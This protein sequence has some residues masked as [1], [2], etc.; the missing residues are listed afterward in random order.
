[1]FRLAFAL[2]M[3]FE[4]GGLQRSFLRIALRCAELGHD[5]HVYTGKWVGEK[6]DHLTVRVLNTRALTNVG[7]N[8]RLAS[9]LQ[10][11]ARDYDC[12]VGFTKIPGLDVYYAGDTCYAARVAENRHRLYKL[13]PR[14]RGYIRQEAGV[15]G[16]R[17]DTEILLIA[18]GE[19]EKFMHHY[20]TDLERFHLLPP[21]VD[22][23]RLSAHVP[24][25]EGIQAYRQELGLPAGGSLLV[26]IGSDFKRKGLNRTLQALSALPS[27][28]LES[29]KLLVVGDDDPAPFMK[30][31]RRLGIEAKVHFLG[32]RRD[33]AKFYRAA[34][35]LVHPAYTENTGQ[36]LLEAMLCGVPVLATENCGFAFH[37]RDAESGLICPV[38]FEQST[39]NRMLLDMLTSP[40]RDEWKRNGPIY[41]E[42]TDLY[43]LIDKAADAIITRAA[44]NRTLQ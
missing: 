15:F 40:R 8:D 9:A 2:S 32:A 13:T 38:P 23:D 16:P 7:S 1:M 29:I 36:I 14:Y 30:L 24:D 33:I 35:L 26:S 27:E 28:L 10:R 6:P 19:R 31:A 5:V 11:A 34:D 41:C 20:G 18:H 37:V 3:F 25:D 12:I 22:R 17:S 42:T 39:L 43:S 44:K 21:G 4:Y